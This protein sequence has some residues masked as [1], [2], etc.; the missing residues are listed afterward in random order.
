LEIPAPQVKF[1][2]I[3]SS[4]GVSTAMRALLAPYKVGTDTLM[5]TGVARIKGILT[6]AQ[7]ESTMGNLVADAQLAAAQ[8]ID[9]QV[10]AAV[11]NYGGLR[12]QLIVGGPIQRETLY[13]LMPFEN[14][15]C[16]VEMPGNVVQHYCNTMARRRG[17]PVA[18]IRYTIEDTLAT[19]I[20]IAGQPLNPVL[21]YKLALNDYNAKG[22]DGC[23]FL[24]PLRRKTTIVLIRDAIISYLSDYEAQG[25]EYIPILDGRVRYAHE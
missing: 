4:T 10:V 23:D 16:I 25:K 5:K 7:P 21:V 20:E 2:K 6:K 14:T 19:N 11:S 18:G 22:G 3:D 12:L 15:V 8:K 13:E 17:W 24:K 9:P 1:Y